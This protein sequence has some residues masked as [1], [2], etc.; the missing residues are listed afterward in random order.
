LEAN[1]D[2]RFVCDMKEKLPLEYAAKNEEVIAL[3]A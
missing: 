3:L 2:L 1:P